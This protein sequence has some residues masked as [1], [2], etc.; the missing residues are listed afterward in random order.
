MNF[1]ANYVPCVG[2]MSGKMILEPK[3][4]NTLGSNIF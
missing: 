4:E 2:N 1:S 3:G